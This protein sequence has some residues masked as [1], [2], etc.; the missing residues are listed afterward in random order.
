MNSDE[1]P[2][3]NEEAR[4]E[5]EYD[6]TCCGDLIDGYEAIDPF[7]IDGQVFCLYCASDLTTLRFEGYLRQADKTNALVK[8]ADDE[9]YLKIWQQEFDKDGRV[10]HI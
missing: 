5:E 9:N 10:K 6:C 4:I 3:M 7:I 1:R 8:A 2:L